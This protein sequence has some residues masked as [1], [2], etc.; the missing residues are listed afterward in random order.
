MSRVFYTADWYLGHKGIHEKFRTQFESEAHHNNVII[1]NYCNTILKRDTVYF[2][3]DICFDK[4]S[5]D[6]IR[7][8]PGLKRLVLGNHENQYG[9]FRTAE[10]FDVFDKVYGLHTRKHVWLS[11]APIHP[12]ELRGK[13]NLHGHV[14]DKTI[15]DPRYVNVCLE[16][17]KYYPVDF[18]ELKQHISEGTIYGADN[19]VVQ[20]TTELGL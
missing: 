2:L 13:P 14:H 12:D 6:V 20:T 4:Y 19:D 5:L 9:K 10:L 1:D 3:G 18:Q 15:K 11:H 16:N 7:K 17:T 8:L